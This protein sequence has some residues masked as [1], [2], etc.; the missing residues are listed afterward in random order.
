MKREKNGKKGGR[1][2]TREKGMERGKLIKREGEREKRKEPGTRANYKPYA[3]RGGM[4]T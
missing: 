2:A 4:V 1:G 3:K